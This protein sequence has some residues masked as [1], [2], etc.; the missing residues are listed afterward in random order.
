MSLYLSYLLTKFICVAHIFKNNTKN[1]ELIIADFYNKS[2]N[3]L[4]HTIQYNKYIFIFIL[5]G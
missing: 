2:K 4:K 5:S 3:Y 1:V